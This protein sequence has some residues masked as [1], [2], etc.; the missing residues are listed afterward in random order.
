MIAHVT[1]LTTNHV[2]QHRGYLS[3]G[4]LKPGLLPRLPPGRIMK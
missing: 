4:Y 2:I 3:D 1:R